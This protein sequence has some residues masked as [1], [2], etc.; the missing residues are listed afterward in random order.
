MLNAGN[1]QVLRIS[2]L[3]VGMVIAFNKKIGDYKKEDPLGSS[4]STASSIEDFNQ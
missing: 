3:H 4:S 1:M 2:Q